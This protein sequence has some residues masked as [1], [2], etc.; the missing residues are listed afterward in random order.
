VLPLERPNARGKWVLV[1]DEDTSVHEATGRAPDVH[2][3]EV[4]LTATGDEALGLLGRPDRGR[5]PDLVVVDERMPGVQVLDVIRTIRAEGS[6][7]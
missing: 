7:S 4:A 1:V 5:E 6:R 2:G 3:Y